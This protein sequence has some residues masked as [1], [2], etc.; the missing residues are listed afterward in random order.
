MTA[1]LLAGLSSGAA[2]AATIYQVTDTSV[3]NCSPHG[4]WTNQEFSD[5][6]CSNFF[7]ISGTLVIEDDL[8]SATL[9]GTAISPDDR[10]ATISLVYSDFAEVLDYKQEGGIPWTPADDATND[11]DFFTSVMG[12]IDIDGTVFTIDELAGT[13]GFQWG[14][15]ANAKDPNAFGASSW[16]QGDM[17]SHHWDLNL[18][19]QEVPEPGTLV[20][21]GLGLVGLMGARRRPKRV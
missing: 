14:L 12:T 18:N 7:S 10:V 21:L 11:I 15:G 9:V 8:S 3:N 19:L 13:F 2:S 6:A 5:S 1:A 16:I 17:A 4:L 20:L